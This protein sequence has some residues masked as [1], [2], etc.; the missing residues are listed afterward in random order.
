MNIKNLTIAT[1]RQLLDS[2]QLTSL[3]LANYF[4]ARINKYDET[5]KACLSFN[6]EMARQQAIEADKR[7]KAGEKGGL[8]GIPYLVKDNI[9]VKEEKATAASKML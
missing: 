7:L 9:L 5:I 4:L 3:E 6:E 1:A 2:Q 8:L